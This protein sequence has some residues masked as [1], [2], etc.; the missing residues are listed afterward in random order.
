MSAA[1]DALGQ[2]VEFGQ[3]FEQAV[4][5][6]G[7]ELLRAAALH[8]AGQPQLEVTGLVDP[9]G[10]RGAAA[11]GERRLA[12]GRRAGRGLVSDAARVAVRGEWISGEGSRF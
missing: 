3:L 1:P 11:F 7:D 2:I 8:R 5:R 6:L 4:E 9:Q 12:L 10:E